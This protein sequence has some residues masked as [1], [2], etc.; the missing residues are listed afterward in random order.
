MKYITICSIIT[1]VLSI[2]MNIKGSQSEIAKKIH[3]QPKYAQSL[4]SFFLLPW[5][6]GQPTLYFSY[7]FLTDVDVNESCSLMKN[8]SQL[9]WKLTKMCS[10]DL[11]SRKSGL[12]L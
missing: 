11:K 8:F 10:A 9:M 7:D 5:K 4:A 1:K 12:S 3:Y 6:S 2:D